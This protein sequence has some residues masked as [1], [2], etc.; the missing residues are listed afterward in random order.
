MLGRML[1]LVSLLLIGALTAVALMSVTMGHRLLNPPRKT[2]AWAVSRSMAG[3]PMEL[4]E[5]RRFEARLVSAGGMELPGWWVPGDDAGGPVVIFTPGWGDSRLGVLPRLGAL[6]GRVSGVLAWE[7]PGFGEAEGTC[8]L[9]V[10][11]PA[12]LAGLIERELAAD[13]SL[14]ARGVVLF[15]SSLGAGVSIVTAAG[16][17]AGEPRMTRYSVCLSAEASAAV[18]GVIAEAPYRLAQTP[19]RNVMRLS[20]LPYRLNGALVFAVLGV[21][22]SARGG[23]VEALRGLVEG[24]RGFDRALH[25]RGVRCPVLVLHP[26]ADE[27]SPVEDGEVIAREAGAETGR[28]LGRLVVVAGAGHNTMWTEEATRSAAAEAVGRFLDEVRSGGVAEGGVGV[29]G[30]MASPGVR[31]GG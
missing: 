27:V 11:E 21:F 26:G 17:R 28:A 4:G 24:W 20:G 18:R 19:A 1:G 3:T 13:P 8:G 29:S 23:M 2:Y 9:G 25:A 15:G 10:T 14:G 22:L 12:L 30:G 16:R 31:D 7:P 6:V 5:A